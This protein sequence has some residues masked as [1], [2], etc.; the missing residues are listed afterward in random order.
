V[1]PWVESITTNSFVACVI[2][3]G[4]GSN[5]NATIDWVAFEGA[6]PGVS[7]GRT[8]FSKWTVGTTCNR[9]SYP[10]VF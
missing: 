10:Q 5:S 3:G 8:A 9:V 7:Q 1:F 4:K 6:Q 2:E